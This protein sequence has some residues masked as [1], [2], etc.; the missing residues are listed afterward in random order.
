MASNFRKALLATAMIATSVA[1]GCGTETPKDTRAADEVAIRQQSMAWSNAAQSHNVDKALSFYA[2]DAIVLPDGKP[3]APTQDAIRSG[4]Q[5][6]LSDNSLTLSWKTTAVGVAKSSDIA[7]EYGSYALDTTGKDGKI[8]TETGK[9]LL[10]WKK[11]PDGSWKVAIDTDN[12]DAP[13]PAAPPARPTRHAA[14]KKHHR[15]H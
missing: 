15:H 2:P 12:S 1:Q 4:W 3:I 6:L 7:Y 8:S 11:Q 13:P 14:A 5:A 9:Y 10:V